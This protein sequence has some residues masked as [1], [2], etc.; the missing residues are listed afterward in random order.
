MWEVLSAMPGA[1]SA[2]L[3]PLGIMYLLAGTALGFVFGVLPGLGGVSALALLIP[4]SYGMEQYH[5]MLLFT[6]SM[7]AV[8]LGGS[9]SAI[10]LNVPG[11]PQNVATAFDG[12]QLA[13]QG[14][15]GLAIGSAAAAAALGAMFSLVLLI[16]L[17]PMVRSIILSFGPPEF[18]M[19]ILFGLVSIPLLTGKNFISGLIAGCIGLSLSFIGFSGTSGVLRY[20]FGTMYLYDGLELTAVVMGLFAVS[21]AIDLVFSGGTVADESIT[22]KTKFSDVLDGV[23]MVFRYKKTF[24]RSSILGTIIG[25]IPGMG[26]VIANIFSWI[27]AS[28]SSPRRAYF[29]KGEVE[30]VIASEAAV[31][32]KDGGALLPTLAFGIPGSGEMAVLMGAF[33]LQGIA[34][35]P[36]FLRDRLDIAWALIIGLLLSNIITSL[37]GVLLARHMAKLTAVKGSIIAPII[38]CA[39]LMGALA[40]RNEPIDMFV[41]LL[42]GF[43]GYVMDKY[44]FSKVTMVL[45]FILGRLAEVSFSQGMMISGNDPSIFVTRPISLGL[46]LALVLLVVYMQ[47]I[48]PLRQRRKLRAAGQTVA[49]KAKKVRSEKQQWWTSMGFY[50]SLLALAWF[51]AVIVLGFTY[52]SRAQLF[53]LSVGL[54]TLPLVALTVLGYLSPRV[55]DALAAIKGSQLFD[56]SLADDLRATVGKVQKSKVDIGGFFTLALWFIGA[57]ILFYVLGF[58]PG[59]AMFMFAFLKYYA[60]H[61][62]KLCLTMTAVSSVTIWV[63][64]SLCLGVSPVSELLMS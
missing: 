41:T 36:Q 19:L 61:D 31:N 46:L 32:A 63:I 26:G 47:G 10:L 37:F 2:A 52:P 13:R 45:G 40:M 42:F 58:L 12:Y 23:K 44:D 53:P 5:A 3:D 6:G 64:F 17:I 57:G 39:S 15:A 34:P 49:S 16:L 48:A 29:G 25:I 24:I 11:T 33:I 60:K 55:A 51:T 20:N 43:I 38:V 56:L 59:T 35:G 21:Q 4:F 8:P 62:L 50:F 1:F 9:I 7:G 30:G 28:Q 14:K 18:L 54:F 27:V 22:I